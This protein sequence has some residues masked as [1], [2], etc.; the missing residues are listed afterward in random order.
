MT[1]ATRTGPGQ[2]LTLAVDG[3][4]CSTCAVRIIRALRRVPGVRRPTVDLPRETVTLTRDPV[5]A[6]DQ[7]VHAALTDA[8]YPPRGDCA[9][10]VD[11][12]A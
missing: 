3:I 6:T 11:Q 2:T 7:V 1:P 10:A 9:P 5:R 4:T 8:G 12:R